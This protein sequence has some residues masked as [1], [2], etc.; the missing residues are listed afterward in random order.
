MVITE[1][2]AFHTELPLSHKDEYTPSFERE[3]KYHL[4]KIHNK[5]L[6]Q[7]RL[8]GMPLEKS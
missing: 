4:R 2:N 7:S 5:L 8:H 1:I 3:V 6:E